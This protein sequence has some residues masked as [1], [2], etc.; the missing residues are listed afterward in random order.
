MYNVTITWLDGQITR[1]LVTKQTLRGF[2]LSA[3]KGASVLIVK[4]RS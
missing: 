1:A 3:C 2:K 4:V